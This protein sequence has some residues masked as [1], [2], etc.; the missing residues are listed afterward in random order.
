M[1]IAGATDPCIRPKAR[2]TAAEI[3]GHPRAHLRD[4]AALCRVPGLVRR[5][6]P[7]TITEIDVVTKLGRLER[8]ATG[9]LLDIS[10]D[11]IAGSGPH[12]ALAHYR[13]TETTNR[14]LQ[15]GDLLVLDGGGQYLDGTTDITRTLP[16]GR[17]APRNAPPSPAC[18]RA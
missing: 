17:P 4:G 6:P 5:Q 1:P 16:V 3:A 13:V 12:G 2:K 11:T 9:E 15:A 18:C 8:R 14:T 7:G 10:F